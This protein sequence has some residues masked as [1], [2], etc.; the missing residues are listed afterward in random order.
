MDF[1]AKYFELTF[2]NHILF[3]HLESFYNDKW[4]KSV[5][6]VTP[7]VSVALGQLIALTNSSAITKLLCGM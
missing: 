4:Y 7:G 2:K 1:D 6:S 3:Y 5:R